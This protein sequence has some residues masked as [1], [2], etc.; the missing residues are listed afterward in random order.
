[1]F[2]SVPKSPADAAVEFDA[3]ELP[4][5]VVEGVGDDERLQPAAATH[6]PTPAIAAIRIRDRRMRKSLS[7]T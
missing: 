6:S 7:F 2:L 4:A 5:A 3:D 1:M